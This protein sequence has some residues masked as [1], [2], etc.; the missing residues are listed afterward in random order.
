MI[1]LPRRN[2]SHS[3]PSFVSPLNR[4]PHRRR[5]IPTTLY[6]PVASTRKIQDPSLSETL[7][8]SCVVSF[9]LSFLRRHRLL[10]RLNR[11]RPRCSRPRLNRLLPRPRP[12]HRSRLRTRRCPSLPTLSS[13]CSSC[14]W[15]PRTLLPPP[16]LRL[17]RLHR[18]RFHPLRF[19]VSGDFPRFFSS[20]RPSS[21]SSGAAAGSRPSIGDD[22]SGSFSCACSLSCPWLNDEATQTNAVLLVTPETNDAFDLKGPSEREKE[23]FKCTNCTSELGK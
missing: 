19:L 8:V 14:S 3:R 12:R 7:N 16:R 21:K 13:S 15:R 11:P 17:H 9:P 22:S 5:R 23:R 4:V 6:P 1:L 2:R 18:P 10:H 20:S